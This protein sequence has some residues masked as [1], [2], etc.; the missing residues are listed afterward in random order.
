MANVFNLFIAQLKRISKNK[1]VILYFLGL[2]IFM[3]GLVFILQKLDTTNEDT[4]TKSKNEMEYSVSINNIALIVNDEQDLWKKFFKNGKKFIL[5]EDA[6][7]KAKELLNDSKI[8]GIIIVDK[9][10]SSNLKKG[11]KPSLKFLERKK[12]QKLELKQKLINKNINMYLL[13]NFISKADLGLNEKQISAE[14]ISVSTIRADNSLIDFALKMFTLM[15]LYIIILSSSTIIN[16][17][18]KFRETKMLTRAISSPNSEIGIILSLLFSFV[19]LQVLINFFLFLAVT[20]IF[21]IQSSGLGYIF[22]AVLSTSA[23]S[24][25]LALVLTRI[26][27]KSE[28]F[29]VAS[30]VVVILTVLFLLLAMSVIMEGMTPFPPILKK[31]AILSPLYWLIDIL[32]K[33]RL[34][35]NLLIVWSII[36]ALITI[37][38]WRLREF[39]RR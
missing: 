35:P 15:L 14:N 26:F 13:N 23:F 8:I 16:E 39:N 19:V 30:T 22:I 6:L 17:L 9:N 5:E 37:G 10:F 20:K 29:S 18:V 32:D 11:E 27:P 12:T 21:G 7:K 34:F 4:D 1:G 3:F 31:L 33:G 38:S 24:L 25:S 36:I 28:Q 2:P